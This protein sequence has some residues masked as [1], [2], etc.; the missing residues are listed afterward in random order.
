MTNII[1][2]NLGYP[3][4]GEQREWKRALESY[5]DG[6]ITEEQLEEKTTEIRL[7]NLKKQK[8][9]G[10]DLIPVGDFSLYDHV[11]DTAVTFGIVP[12]RFSYDGGVVDY[13]TYFAIARGKDDAVA[14]EMTK[15][16]NTNY[17]YIVPELNDVT[18]KLVENRALHYYEEAKEKLQIDGKPVILG[19]ITFLKLSKG[20]TEEEFA[21][22]VDTFIP[23]YVEQLKELEAA[24]ATWVQ[25]DEPIFVTKVS[26]ETLHLTKKVYDTFAKEVPGLKLLFQTY[27]EKIY[28]YA[29]I[30]QLPV[31]GFG[32]DF[33][34]GD[35]LEQ[36]RQFGFPQGKT[37]AAGIVNGRNVWRA[38]L[39]EKLTI[40][41]TLT[42][43]VKDGDIIVQPSCSLLHVPVTKTLEE[44]IDQVILD[45]LSFADEKLDE[46]VT[47]TKG[48]QKGRQAISSEIEL[49]DEALAKLKD[50][51][52]SNDEVRKETAAL[53]TDDA[54]RSEPFTEP[55]SSAFG[56][57]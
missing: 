9:L 33:V 50:T 42:Q 11:L 12:S 44:K 46:I 19:P 36:I 32:I 56:V 40:L 51:Y 2:S 1:S 6:A 29:E 16:F 48:L 49:V 30:T 28:N 57:L 7:N 41:E 24:G 38:N 13:D 27:F 21:R 15:W 53:T 18:P 45:G 25:I 14:S 35:S 8:E 39:G 22:L 34:H 47:L 3:R 17:H 43:F 4:I 10:V 26:E 55:S 37:L 20:Y 5:W 52:R 31:A 54:K 23:L